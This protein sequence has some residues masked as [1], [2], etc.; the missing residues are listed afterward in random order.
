MWS[1]QIPPCSASPC[2]TWPG[3]GLSAVSSS[4]PWRCCLPLSLPA[5][6]ASRAFSG[7]WFICRI[8]SAQWPWRPCGYSMSTAPST[9]WLK[10]SSRLWAWIPWQRYSGWIMTTSSW[11]CSWPTVSAWWVITCW[12]LPAALSASATIILRRPLWTGPISSTSSAIL[13]YHC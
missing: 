12:Y 2:G 4:C 13:H 1:W 8:L 6:S 3:Y 7:Q 11:L 5:A 9:D 10:I